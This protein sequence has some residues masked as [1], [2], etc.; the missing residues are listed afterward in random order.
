[1]DGH[2]RLTDQNVVPIFT[3]FFLKEFLQVRLGEKT[4]LRGLRNVLD[5]ISKLFE[6]L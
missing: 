1:M 6:N 3:L 2:S 5:M 4:V